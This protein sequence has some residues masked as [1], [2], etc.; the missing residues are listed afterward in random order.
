MNLRFALDQLHQAVDRVNFR[1]K[2]A[3]EWAVSAARS[4]SRAISQ[5]AGKIGWVTTWNTRCGIATYSDHLIQNMPGEITVLAAHSQE[6]TGNDKAGVF[7][8][9][10]AGE[11]DTLADLRASI[12]YSAIETLVIQFHY[13]FFNFENLAAFL[14]EQIDCG[15]VICVVLHAT[16]DPVDAPYKALSIL[17]PALSRCHRLLVHSPNDMNR[18]KAYGLLDNVALFPHGILDRS[19]KRKERRNANF[20]VASYGF[21]RPHKGLIELIEA[22]FLLKNKGFEIQLKMVNAEYPVAESA[23]TIASAREMIDRYRLGDSIELHTSFLDDETSLNILSDADLIVFP[24]QQSGESSSGAVRYGLAT[25]RPVAVTPL[26]IFEDVAGVVHTLPG[27]SPSEIAE[28]I[29][30]IASSLKINDPNALSIQSRF[31]EWRDQ[32]AYSIVSKRLH[33]MICAL[34]PSLTNK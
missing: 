16:I 5:D 6:L 23:A 26:E 1:W 11:L 12:E 33:N 14:N 28:G 20:V 15:R 2:N 25:G 34:M 27:T 9:W 30:A 7:R 21:F 8:C 31:D 13:G 10:S 22:V 3:A 32:H 19:P 29:K 24:Y 4:F 18:L 17:A